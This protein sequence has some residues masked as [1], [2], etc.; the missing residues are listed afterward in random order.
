MHMRAPR[1]PALPP[2]AAGRYVQA[3]A[4]FVEALA[5]A[6]LGF[7]ARDPHLASAKN[8]LAEFYRNTRQWAKAEVLYK[9]VRR[10]RLGRG[11]GGG[12]R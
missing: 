5:E 8:N 2:C 10:L 3:E 12:W 7:G 4:K 6:Q 1:P 9:E 11:W